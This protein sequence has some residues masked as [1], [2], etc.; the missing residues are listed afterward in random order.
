VLGEKLR[1]PFPVVVS[2]PFQC[3]YKRAKVLREGQYVTWIDELFSDSLEAAKMTVVGCFV[4]KV[5]AVEPPVK[6]AVEPPVKKAAE[7]P[8]K[9]GLRKGFLNPRPKVLVNPTSLRGFLIPLKEMVSPYL[10]IGLSVLI[11]MEILWFGRRAMSFGMAC[12]WIG[13][14]MVLLR[15]KPWLFGTPWRKSF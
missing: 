3:Y 1:S 2:K 12:P 13:L 11:I 10:A 4:K 8:V 15:R 6:K 9:Q 14:W 5:K 7:P